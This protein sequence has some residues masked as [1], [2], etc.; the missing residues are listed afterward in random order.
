MAVEVGEPVASRAFACQK[1]LQGTGAGVKW[2]DPRQYHVTLKF[3]GDVQEALLPRIEAALGRAA[4]GQGPFDLEFGGIGAF[5][6][7]QSPSVIWAGCGSGAETLANLA[8][9]VEAE[10]AA[11]GF[12]PE[13]R[14]F[15]P[16]LTLGRARERGPAPALTAAIKRSAS[17]QF[18]KITV[19]RILLM[20]S[21]LT[22]GGPIYSLLKSVN[23]TAQKVLCPTNR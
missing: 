8:A 1:E 21:V 16:H 23:L 3:L 22:P 18:G 5:P 9:R 11:I 13:P 6:R 10:M 17:S 19:D 20:K 2:V 4:L 15:S 12:A 7:V 14:P